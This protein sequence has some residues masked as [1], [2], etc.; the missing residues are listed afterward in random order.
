MDLTVDPAS[1][2]WISASSPV[3]TIRGVCWNISL[4]SLYIAPKSGLIFCSMPA[5]THASLLFLT[6]FRY[7]KACKT[8]ELVTSASQM[9]F[10]QNEFN[11]RV[12]YFWIEKRGQVYSS[13]VQSSPEIKLQVFSYYKNQFLP[14]GS[15][16]GIFS[17]SAEY[18][19]IWIRSNFQ[20]VGCLFRKKKCVVRNGVSYLSF[21]SL[22]PD[23]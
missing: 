3:S 20:V 7:S 2:E 13:C 14:I 5:D 15:N 4:A 12:Q 6:C 8:L 18:E 17:L 10:T 11:Y 22:K 16:N 1:I 9:V 21:F 23:W 19:C